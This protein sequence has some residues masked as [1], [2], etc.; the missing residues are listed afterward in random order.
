[1][2]KRLASAANYFTRTARPKVPSIEAPVAALGSPRG[3]AKL[4]ADR[5]ID[6]YPMG[7]APLEVQAPL[8]GNHGLRVLKYLQS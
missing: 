4:R 7:G 3:S 2:L 5:P 1:M 8:D 6:P